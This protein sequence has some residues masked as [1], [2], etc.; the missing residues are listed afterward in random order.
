MRDID[1]KELKGHD[2]LALERF[3]DTTHWM[4]EFVENRSGDKMRYFLTDEDYQTALDCQK[5]RKIRIQRYARVVEG[6]II[7]FKPKKVRRH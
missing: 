7:D 1:A 6:H 5:K 3:N 4:I 2:I